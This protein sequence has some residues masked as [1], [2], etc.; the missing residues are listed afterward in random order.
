[1]ILH[2]SRTLDSVLVIEEELDTA[3]RAQEGDGFKKKATKCSRRFSVTRPFLCFLSV[4]RAVH[5]PALRDEWN[6]PAGSSA[7]RHR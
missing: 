7:T 6:T 3:T 4:A 5:A 1:M 2:S